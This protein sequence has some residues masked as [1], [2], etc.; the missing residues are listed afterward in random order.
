[1]KLQ[2]GTLALAREAKAT[3]TEW[4]S[5]VADILDEWCYGVTRRCRCGR[6]FHNSN[7]CPECGRFAAI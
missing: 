3:Y 4:R 1:M 2:P 5:V 6:S 7:R